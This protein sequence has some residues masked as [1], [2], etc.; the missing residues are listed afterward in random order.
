VYHRASSNADGG[1]TPQTQRVVHMRL[2]RLL[3]RLAL[4]LRAPAPRRLPHAHPIRPTRDL[5]RRANRLRNRGRVGEAIDRVPR[6]SWGVGLGL[7]L[8]RREGGRDGRDA[9]AR[10]EEPGELARKR[11]GRGVCGRRGVCGGGDNG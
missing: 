5:A 4:Q 7:G 11:C 9:G 8:H 3:H 6:V 1:C 10:A 2:R